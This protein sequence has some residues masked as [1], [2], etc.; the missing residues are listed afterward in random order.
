MRSTTLRN[1]LFT[2][3][4]LVLTGVVLVP[5]AAA[6]PTGRTDDLLQSN[7]NAI[8][9]TG[10][11]GVL[12]ESVGPRGKRFA[13]AGYADPVAKTPVRPGDTFRIGSS[14]KT[15]VST[16]VLQ[17]VGEGRISLDDPVDRW[18]PGVV[19]GNGNDGRDITVRQLLQ[20]TAGLYDYV[21]DLPGIAST[22]G[23]EA[24]RYRHYEPA[25]LVAI[26]MKHKPDFAPGADWKYSNTD[27]ILAGMII[28]KV[29][30]Q[31]WRKQVERRIIQPLGLRHT[32]VPGDD[33]TLPGRHL[34]GYSNFGSGAAIDVTDVNMSWGG[35]AGEIVSTTQDLASFYQALLRGDLLK[36]AQL[37]E[38]KSTV[39]VN[40]DFNT[41][42]PGARYG[43][44]LMWIPLTCGGGY[45]SHGGNV[46]GYSTRDGVSSDGKRAVVVE[47]TGDGS[48]ADLKTERA[49][50]RLVDQRFCATNQK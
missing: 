44:G 35:A 40:E 38:M 46:N 4:G 15:F 6:S 17:L 41:I 29:T 13:T 37:A 27:Y 49:M 9:A 5:E 24:N 23:F 28:E 18:L 50:D 30:G 48:G 3:T 19:S 26:A 20:H 34:K 43:L 33:P 32:T 36:E 12:A 42:W 16:V 8:A 1:V 25:D 10:T 22:E 47:E 31:S 39:P 11:V 21:A 14:T 7:A 45:W 2:T